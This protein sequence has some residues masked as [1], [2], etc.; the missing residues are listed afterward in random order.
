MNLCAYLCGEL[1]KYTQIMKKRI[2]LAAAAAASIYASNAQLNSPQPQ[3]F[4]DRAKAMYSDGNYIG[5]LDQ[6][7]ALPSYS[8]LSDERIAADYYRAAATVHT[9]TNA[10]IQLIE[11][12][13][14]SYPQST[15]VYN[16]YILLGN[17]YFGNDDSKALSIYEKVP[18][19]ALTGDMADLLCYNMA[20]CH[21]QQGD[22]AQAIDGFEH[23]IMS[24]KYYNAAIFYRAY[25]AYINNEYNKA[26]R[27][28]DEVDPEEAPGNM[29]EFYLSQIAY[30]EDDYERAYNMASQLLNRKG[31]EPQFRNEALRVAGE[32]SYALGNYTLANDLLSKYVNRTDNPIPSAMY[33][34][35]QNAYDSGDY[36]KAIRYLG[37]VTQCDNAMGQSA[38]L[39]IGQAYLHEKEYNSAAMAFNR[40][41]NMQ[42]DE[43]VRETA[44]YNYA[45]ATTMGGRVPFTSTVSVFNDFLEYYPNSKYAPQVQK[46]IVNTYL[47]D[48]NYAAA[49]ESINKMRQPSK[50][51]LAAKQRALHALGVKSL[52]ASDTKQALSYLNEARSLAKYDKDTDTDVSLALGEAL[53]ANGEYA[54]AASEIQNYISK[55]K[56][57]APNMPLAYYDLGY[58]LFAQKNYAKAASQF[59]KAI[60]NP[61]GLT[62][63]VIAD[64]YNRLGD[65]SY[66]AKDFQKAA[67]AYSQA[68]SKNPTS[69]DYAM[70][71]K[72][73][74]QGFQREHAK[75]VATLDDMR[76]RYPSSALVPDALLETTEAYLQLGKNTE[77]LK[78]YKTLVNDYPKTAQARQGYLQMALVKQNS[79]DT[80][81]AMADYKKLIKEYP[82]SEE[83]K[84]A[85]DNMKRISAA[86]GT[87]QELSDFLAQTS[88]AP[89]LEAPEMEQ[90][91]FDEAEKQYIENDKTEKLIV[92]VSQYQNSGVRDRALNYIIEGSLAKGDDATVYQY[93]AE[94]AERYPSSPYAQQALLNKA[95]IEEKQGKGNLALRSWSELTNTASSPEILLTARM[96]VIRTGRDARKHP[97]VIEAAKAVLAS[98]GVNADQCAEAAYSLGEALASTK[99][100][101]EA[102]S[103][104]EEVADLTDNIY[105]IRSAYALAQSYFDSSN[106]QLAEEWAKK[107]AN[108][109]SPHSYWIARGFILLSDI[110]AAQGDK[111]KARQYLQALK[112]NYT[113]QND[114][115]HT[116]IDERL[117]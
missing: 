64:A 32:S 88:G 96:G 50:E 12:F 111:Y 45:V 42:Y 104:W 36:N 4:L 95:T 6:L 113:D 84:Q 55:S 52:A 72:A 116:M 53:Y 57:T 75:K 61:A 82:S 43:D 81:G 80:K 11:D 108:A 78:I 40:A 79:G 20:Y 90:L 26:K 56:S 7:S 67:D 69:G 107:A 115:I 41:L 34:L 1:R 46:H 3:G 74:M 112:D 31:I 68:Y 29:A 71:Q 86:G 14:A 33:I 73:L 99:K 17:C 106:Y 65:C 51:T 5:C 103:A 19:N 37:D 60:N 8:L 49:L 62:P 110:Y 9:D 38:N 27:L 87:L 63:A 91:A 59:E 101:S 97:E 89:K 35:G 15:L 76:R 83:A 16:A 39:Y 77:A 18:E 10:A 47:T 85:I 22:Y 94:L 24:P 70:F 2:L 117:K 102:Q 21:M 28:F 66:Y 23:L 13:I 114:D 92:F 100:N 30:V 105:G 25:I 109:D 48:N 44:Y 98:S 54:K 93:S 58:A